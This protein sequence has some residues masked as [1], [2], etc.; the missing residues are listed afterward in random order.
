[1]D[2][3]QIKKDCW[4]YVFYSYGTI[5][6]FERRA[7]RFQIGRIWITFLGIV[8]PVVVGSIVM[9][10]GTDSN[11]LKY[12]IFVAGVVTMIQLI[13]STWSIVSRW[14]EKYEYAMNSVAEN[15]RLYNDWENY[16]KRKISNTNE[17][18]EIFNE[19]LSRTEKQEFNDIKQNVSDKEKRFANRSALFYFKQECHVCNEIPTTMTP[20][21]CAGCGNF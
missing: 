11:S 6:I 5:R 4:G 13:L 21:K 14:D 3:E 9:S 17:S 16:R 12:F 15:T 2:I 18:E 8:V 1:M 19:I 20:C 10:F 7:K